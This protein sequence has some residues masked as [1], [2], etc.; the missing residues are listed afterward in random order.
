MKKLNQT[1]L[2][3][4]II[5]G[6]DQRAMQSAIL[7][8]INAGYNRGTPDHVGSELIK[9]KNNARRSGSSIIG[10]A[11]GEYER[12]GGRVR[13]VNL[14]DQQGRSV[15]P[16]VIPFMVSILDIDSVKKNPVFLLNA[17]RLGR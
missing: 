12:L 4:S 15:I 9:L 13:I 1:E 3:S 6:S 17:R 11:I 7:G 14:T 10:S 5:K 16:S 8:K 2:F